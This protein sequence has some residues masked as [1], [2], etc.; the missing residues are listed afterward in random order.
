[1]I[2]EA[3]PQRILERGEPVTLPPM[4]ILQGALDDNVLPEVQERF[5]ATY[6][7]AGGE[8]DFEIYPGAEHRWIIQ[9]GPQ[10]DRAIAMIKAFIAR[11]LH[12][13]QPAR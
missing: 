8:I 4:F 12:A 13:Q 1:T 11:Q 3:N 6:R 5:V 2:Y 9:P 10:T 7:A